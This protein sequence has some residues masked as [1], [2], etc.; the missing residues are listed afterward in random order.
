LW[1]EGEVDAARATLIK[2]TISS[3]RLSDPQREKKK[4]AVSEALLRLSREWTS[5]H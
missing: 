3:R 4:A 2:R 5:L 1:S